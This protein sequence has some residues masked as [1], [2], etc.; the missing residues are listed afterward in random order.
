MV[1]QWDSIAGGLQKNSQKGDV[2]G[3]DA[4]SRK[5]GRCVSQGYRMGLP[6]VIRSLI[7]IT[8]DM[9]FGRAV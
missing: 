5:G 6:Q 3:L 7:H 1:T 9:M 8:G 2:A 4:K